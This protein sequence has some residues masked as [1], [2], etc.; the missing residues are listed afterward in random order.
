MALDDNWGEFH[1]RFDDPERSLQKVEAKVNQLEKTQEEVIAKGKKMRE[2]ADKGN[3]N[4]KLRLEAMEKQQ[5]TM[6][7][8]GIGLSVSAGVLALLQISTLAFRRVKAWYLR[9]LEAEENARTE[10]QEDPLK[11]TKTQLS[12]GL[13]RD[14]RFHARQWQVDGR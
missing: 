1:V 5:Q 10:V 4:T 13:R 14:R 7:K 2:L 3:L 6:Q 11:P 9:K 8:V 12:Q